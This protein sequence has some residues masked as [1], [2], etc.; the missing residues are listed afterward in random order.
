MIVNGEITASCVALFE[1]VAGKSVET[2]SLDRVKASRAEERVLLAICAYPASEEGDRLAKA[3]Y[4]LQIE[5]RGELDLSEQLQAI[6]HSS[7][8]K[9]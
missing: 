6:L 2:L 4:L 3:R 5:A 9:G 8:S 7:M 1:D